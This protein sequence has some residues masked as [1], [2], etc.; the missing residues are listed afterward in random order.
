MTI[1]TDDTGPLSFDGLPPAKPRISDPPREIPPSLVFR[2]LVHSDVCARTFFSMVAAGL[3]FAVTTRVDSFE[4]GFL[5]TFGTIA[6]FLALKKFIPALFR[7]AGILRRMR[8]GVLAPGRVL[9]CRPLRADKRNAMPYSKFLG[10]WKKYLGQMQMD[11]LSGCMSSFGMMV[12]V[13]PLAVGML[14]VAAVIIAQAIGHPLGDAP[15]SPDLDAGFLGKWFGMGLIWIAVVVIFFR[16]CRPVRS[17]N[18]DQNADG[19]TM[20]DAHATYDDYVTLL[21]ARA[22]AEGTQIS[23][24]TPLPDTDYNYHLQCA[25]EYFAEGKLCLAEGRLKVTNRLDIS[26]IEPLL[27][28]PGKP[29]SVE[30]FAG[31][32]VEARFDVQ[33]QW[34]RAPAIW[35]AIRVGLAGLFAVAAIALFSWNV[36]G[37]IANMSKN[38]DLAATSVP[39]RPTQR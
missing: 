34:E 13:G 22:K 31:L 32:P 19:A 39:D 11:G 15:L 14:I 33:G 5:F 7:A 23:L 9:S 8:T 6:L 27:F 16:L 29:G 3:Q 30:M 12:F 35:P 18:E 10:D 24:A 17:T 21:I 1:H 36:P 25:V 38:A 26:G 4:R 28:V 20:P 37:V 2:I